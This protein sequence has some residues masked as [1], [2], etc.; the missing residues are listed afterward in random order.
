MFRRGIGIRRSPATLML[1]GRGIQYASQLAMVLLVPTALA[2]DSYVQLNLVL[3]RAFLGAA[4]AFGWFRSGVTW[5]AYELL[6]SSYD[7]VRRP[8]CVY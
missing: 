5:Y 6:D 7:G 3:T 2:P 8:Y 1:L 4:S